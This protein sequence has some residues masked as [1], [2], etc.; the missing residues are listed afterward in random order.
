MGPFTRCLN[1]VVQ[2]LAL[3]G[4]AGLGQ[5]VCHAGAA[6]QGVVQ[7]QLAHIG[8]TALLHTQMPFLDQGLHGL[9]QGVAVHAKLF[10]ELHITGQPLAGLQAA[11]GDVLA[12]GLCDLGP[13]ALGCGAW[14][15]HV[16][17]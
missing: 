13:Q 11:L 6:L 9:A 10:G 5:V 14:S 4:L 7:H 12:Q 17:S 1:L 15:G 2:Q 3:G 16:E 8:A